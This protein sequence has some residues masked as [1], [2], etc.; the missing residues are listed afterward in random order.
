MIKHTFLS[1][2]AISF[3][4]LVLGMYFSSDMDD[5]LHLGFP[6]QVVKH[7]DGS[8]S[9][10]KIQLGKTIFS[11]VEQLFNEHAEVSLFKPKDKSAVIEAYFDK[12]LI[13][14]LSSKIIISFSIDEKRLQDI[15]ERGARISTLGSGTRRVTLSSDDQILIRNE[16]VSSITYLPAINLTAEL[17]E[18]RFG[19]PE[20]KIIENNTDTEHWLYPDIGV[21]VVLN[22][23]QKEVI[24]T[25]C[26]VVLV[27][28]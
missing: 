24:I 9:V 27:Q 17:I 16:R 6:W 26:R 28:L 20:N 4:A 11:E 21:D 13:G 8:T 22:E 3:L 15:F 2:L 12:V 7:E 1:V 18:K 25:Y 10:F 14:G 23:K 19:K 5:S